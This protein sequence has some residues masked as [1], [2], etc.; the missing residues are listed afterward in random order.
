[1][2]YRF[3]AALALMLGLETVPALAA[4]PA[5]PP[6]ACAAARNRVVQQQKAIADIDAR[7]GKEQQARANCAAGKNC[8]K[9]D[10]T[11]EALDR[12]K[13]ELDAK[14]QRY[15]EVEAK[16]CAAGIGSAGTATPP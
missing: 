10:R 4:D 13:A 5:R 11:I 12:R 2:T 7:I 14:V 6:K 3:L 15:R 16:T 1:M 9:F 8:R